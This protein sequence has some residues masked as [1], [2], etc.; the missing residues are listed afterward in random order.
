MKK[1]NEPMYNAMLNVKEEKNTSN[2]HPIDC[3][4]VI[5]VGGD[6]SCPELK[7]YIHCR[8]CPVMTDAAEAFFNRTPPEGYLDEWQQVLEATPESTEISGR[9]VLIFRLADEWF[10]LTPRILLKSPITQNPHYSSPPFCVRQRSDSYF[11]AALH[12]SWVSTNGP[13]EPERLLIRQMTTTEVFSRLTMLRFLPLRDS[14]SPRSLQVESH[15]DGPSRS[16]KLLVST[17]LTM[18]NYERFHR[19][20]A[21]L[22]NDFRALCLRGIR[23]P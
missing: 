7:T 17:V 1:T 22:A 20:S 4:R 8:N 16:M 12:G 23:V 19:L 2:D 5:G 14:W 18:R 9:S 3:W 15:V 6:R 11:S 21:S 10:S 13:A